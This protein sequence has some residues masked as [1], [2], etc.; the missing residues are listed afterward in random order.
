M[1]GADQ[2][3]QGMRHQQ[4][5]KADRA[6]DRDHGR[7]GQRR[8]QVDDAR[9]SRHIDPSPAAASLPADRALD[10]GR[11]AT[12]DPAPAAPAPPCAAR[13]RSA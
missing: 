2:G 5:D 12:A 9:R 10:R 3:P 11:T 13:G 4:S 7:D 8:C 6:S 1:I